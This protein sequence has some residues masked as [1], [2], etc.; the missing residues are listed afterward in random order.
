M[1]TVRDISAATGLSTATVSRALRG[2]ACVSEETRQIVM[3]AA[4]KLGHSSCHVHSGDCIVVLTSPYEKQ[5]TPMM[6]A[7]SGMVETGR[8]SGYKIFDYVITDEESLSDIVDMVNEGVFAGIIIPELPSGLLEIIMRI[9]D[10]SRIVQCCGKNDTL[11][12][13]SVLTDDAAAARKATEYLI[14]LGHKKI[15]VLAHSEKRAFSRTRMDAYVNAMTSHGLRISDGWIH[16]VNSTRYEFAYQIA[17]SALRAPDRPSA[18]F[19]FTDY[20]AMAL[21]NAAQDLKIRIPEELSVIGFDDLELAHIKTPAIT[22][23][24]QPFEQMG[25]IACSLL[26]NSITGDCP[27]RTEYLIDA[28]LIIRETTGAAPAE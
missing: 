20:Y 23:I 25:N 27:T 7:I 18:F 26:V 3:E 15:G 22:T 17:V 5:I 9:E 10:K 11:N 19:A 24:H 28:D 1:A 12:S 13:P 2:Q 14:S 6:I 16:Y 8:A 4:K 21:V